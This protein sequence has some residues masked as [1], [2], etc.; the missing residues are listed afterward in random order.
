MKWKGIVSHVSHLI[1]APTFARANAPHARSIALSRRDAVTNI[2]HGLDGGDAH[3]LAK[4]P[5]ADVHDV[6]MRVEVIAPDLREQLLAADDLPGMADEVVQQAEL[7]VGEICRRV[8]EPH[9]TAREVEL[10][11]A[12]AHE[13][14][15]RLRSTRRAELHAHP[16]DQ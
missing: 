15:V 13:Q 14:L 5:D 11:A 8:T 1:I 9:A 3:L 16:R 7:A 6:R 10:Q 12:G 4:A 2:A